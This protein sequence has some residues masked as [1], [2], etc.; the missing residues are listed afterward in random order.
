MI[1]TISCSYLGGF[2]KI[3][4]ICLKEGTFFLSCARLHP[5]L[6]YRG[7]HCDLWW[8]CWWGDTGQD[9]EHIVKEDGLP[10]LESVLLSL[11]TMFSVD[12]L[13]VAITER[14]CVS[15]T[16]THTRTHKHTYLHT[17]VCIHLLALLKLPLS[18]TELRWLHWACQPLR[19]ISFVILPYEVGIWL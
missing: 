8:S 3:V 5:L 2:L 10:Q 6:V 16:H 14:L 18:L 13:E 19:A 17:Y 4:V 1:K 12:F 15:N 7:S 9:T 11:P